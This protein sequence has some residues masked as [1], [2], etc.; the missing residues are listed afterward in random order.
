MGFIIK[1]DFETNLGPTQEL[2]ARIE[3]FTFNKVTAQLSF[4][5]TYWIDQASAIRHNRVFLDEEVKGMKGLVQD[6]L[7]YFDSP[8]SSG[9]EI[10]LSQF[11]RVIVSKEDEVETP[12]YEQ[13]MIE[14]E[15]PF[16]SFDDDGDEVMKTRIIKKPK[17]VQIGTI[18]ETR[19]VIDLEAFDD[20]YGYVYRRL[21]Q[22]LSTF[23]NEELIQKV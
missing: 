23:F 8:D 20:I 2:Y 3:G 22:Y 10:K 6:N 4:Q 1:A 7:I 16:I 17:E 13:Q 19:S 12:E 15:V 14:V 9:K 11:E 18:L 21:K 5:I